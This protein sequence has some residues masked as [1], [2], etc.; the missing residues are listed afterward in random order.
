MLNVLK[1]VM[2]A[3]MLPR[4][5]YS[6]NILK[7]ACENCPL[8]DAPKRGTNVQ[9]MFDG[10]V[11][12]THLQGTLVFEKVLSPSHPLSLAECTSHDY[13]KPGKQRYRPTHHSG[14]QRRSGSASGES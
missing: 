6:L 13:L 11:L 5:V 9:L 10:F 7:T 12:N 8:Q 4:S 1:A 2:L 14:F 3:M